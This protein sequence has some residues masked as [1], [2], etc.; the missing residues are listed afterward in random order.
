[1]LKKRYLF[2]LGVLLIA[3]LVACAGEPVEVTRVV[4]VPVEVPGETVE[5]EVTRVVEVMPEV[6]A[7]AVSVIPFEAEWANSPHNMADAEAFIHWNE[8][9]P[10]EVPASCAKCHSTPGYLDFLGADGT[11]F[12]T[13]EN[14]VPVGTTI[15]CQACH[16]NVTIGLTSVVFPSGIE[17]HG[18]G[19]ES[20][21]MQCHQGRAS[22]FTVDQGIVDAGLDPIADLDTVSEDVGFSNIHYFAAAATLYGTAAK[23]GYE[24]DGKVYDSKF[25]HVA[26]YDSC[27]D[28]H[29]P[30]TLEVKVEECS[31]C[32]TNVSSAED[33][34]NIRMPGSLVDYDGDGNMQEGIMGEIEGMQELL[35][36]AMQAYSA[37]IG[38]S[39]ITYDAAAYPYFFDEAGERFAAWT[40]RLA[41]AAYNYQVS[42]KDPGEFAHGGK[43]IIELLYDSTESLNQGMSSPV[44]MTNVRRIDHGHF[45]GS[46][47]A[48]RHWDEEGVVSASC[49]KCH[50]SEGLPLFLTEGVSIS[51]EPS[52]GLNCATCHSDLTTF[53]LYASPE[54]TFPSG[55]TVSLGDDEEAQASNLCIN[56]HQGRES[57]ASVDRRI[58]ALGDNEVS[59]SLGFINIH[60]FAAGA[61]LF[62][63]D[64]KGIYEF[65]GQEYLGRNPHVEAFDTCIECHSAHALEVKVESCSNCHDGVDTAEDLHSIRVT[66]IDFDG[67]GDVT[68]GLYGEIETMNEALYAAIQAYAEAT[69]GVDPIVYNGSSYPYFFNG[70]GERYATWTPALVRATYNYQY[71][72]KDPGNFA[73]NGLYIIQVLYDTLNSLGADTSAMTRPEAIAAE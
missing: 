3:V 59:D 9:D 20:R 61:T 68:E 14:N 30:H 6:P 8:E 22:K 27:I 70:A 52:N 55:A 18:L 28:C 53:A 67:D 65:A 60:Y 41:Q 64:V 29:N 40:P 44:D 5:V 23:G 42:Q 49:T 1:M 35:Y 48:F 10:K 46:E 4:E 43:Y 24:Y 56:C 2:I 58:G 19:D 73:H 63:T 21:C 12:G 51:Q 15:E 34:V 36:S 13:V 38:G 26:G 11:A 57:A 37:E 17:I 69:D 62:G 32:H 31:V 16:N 66:E 47:E 7:P 25:E 39:T 33:L 45:A 72:Q 54:V 50:T 71:V